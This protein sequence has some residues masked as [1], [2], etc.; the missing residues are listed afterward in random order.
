MQRKVEEMDI[1]IRFQIASVCFYLIIASQFFME[2]R[3]PTVTN[4]IFRAMIIVCGLNL[5][6]DISTVCSLHYYEK[7]PSWL[8]RMLHQLFIGSLDLFIALLCLFVISL[9]HDL[10]YHAKRHILMFVPFVISIIVIIFGELD[11]YIGEDVKYSYGMMANTVYISVALYLLLTLIYLIRYRKILSKRIK[12]LLFTAIA[13]EVIMSLIQ[14]TNPSILLSGLAITLMLTFI[15]YSMVNPSEYIEKET[16]ILNRYAFLTMF[17]EKIGSNKNFYVFNVTFDNWSILTTRFGQDFVSHLLSDFARFMETMFHTN[18]YHSRTKCLSMFVEGD[19]DQIYK[20]SRQINLKLEESITIDQIK[21]NLKAHLLAV[22][23]PKYAKSQQDILDILELTMHDDIQEKPEKVTFYDEDNQAIVNRYI[24]IER[25]LK[26]AVDFNGFTVVYQPIYSAKL[27]RIVSCEALVRLK[28]TQTIGFVSPEEF[29]LIA[30]RIG[31]IGELGRIVFTKVCEFAKQYSLQEKGIKYIEVNLSAIQ[32]M[33]PNLADEL[34]AIMN[35]FDLP[36]KFFNF[37][38]TESAAIETNAIISKNINNLLAAGCSFSMD[39]YG[40]GYSN[41]TMMVDMPYH[42]IKLD[43][44]LIWPCYPP[45]QSVAKQGEFKENTKSHVVL[46]STI[47]MIKN[48]SYHI[49][50]EGVE[51]KEQ[52]DALLSMG[53]DYIQGYYFSKPVNPDCF[54]RKLDDWNMIGL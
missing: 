3:L 36:G 49:V 38:I 7:I 23:C 33:N 50:A 51:T 34:I 14:M 48:L 10:R 12:L 18:V 46:Q 54:F 5:L 35:K 16:D 47:S 27:K 21:V 19:K 22:E 31:V 2:R 24:T 17:N 40:T 11:Y 39:D 28:D 13:G 41:L 9:V 43:K 42:I 26:D 4:K 6:F 45:Q 20:I 32:Y 44:S 8:N 15:F 30:E 37:E 53:V 1:E 52:L 25:M 29:I